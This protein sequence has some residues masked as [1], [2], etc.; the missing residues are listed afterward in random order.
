[1]KANSIFP[2]LSSLSKE[3]FGFDVNIPDDEEIINTS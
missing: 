3:N 2:D 1:M